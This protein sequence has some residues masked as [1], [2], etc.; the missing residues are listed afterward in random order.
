M[1]KDGRNTA[2]LMLTVKLTS[3]SLS[4]NALDIGVVNA[5]MGP[6]E[7]VT[8][9]LSKNCAISINHRLL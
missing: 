1:I 9:Q 4:L 3:K 8:I 7:T 2:A 5:V 6:V